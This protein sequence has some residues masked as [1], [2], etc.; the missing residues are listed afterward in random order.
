MPHFKSVARGY[1]RHGGRR[2]SAFRSASRYSREGDATWDSY[3]AHIVDD[4][5]FA[6]SLHVI[7]SPKFVQAD[8]VDAFIESVSADGVGST[9]EEQGCLRFDVYQNVNDP[10]ELYLYE[11]YANPG[12][13]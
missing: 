9:H 5:Y 10:T 8:K 7:H 1:W 13:V 6:S 12:C 4:E 2:R 3:R 11:V